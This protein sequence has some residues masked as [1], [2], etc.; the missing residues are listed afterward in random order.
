MKCENCQHENELHINVFKLEDLY[1]LARYA[2]YAKSEGG[3]SMVVHL[4]YWDP[5]EEEVNEI[6]EWIKEEI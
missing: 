6:E 2:V 3:K 5:T 4:Q 1:T